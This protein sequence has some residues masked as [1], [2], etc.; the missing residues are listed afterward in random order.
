MI[1]VQQPSEPDSQTFVYLV[2]LVVH[3]FSARPVELGGTKNKATTQA[4]SS[5]TRGCI[6]PRCRYRINAPL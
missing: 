2:R 3:K 1:E 5:V 4:A 6:P